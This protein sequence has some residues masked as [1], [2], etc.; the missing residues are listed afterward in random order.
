MNT[1][2]RSK[3]ERRGDPLR[4]AVIQTAHAIHGIPHGGRIESSEAMQTEGG[5]GPVSDSPG[6]FQER[7]GGDDPS[8]RASPINSASEW[9]LSIVCTRNRNSLTASG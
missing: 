1:L 2:Q 4:G 7:R 5:P 8:N 6:T 3:R 9:P